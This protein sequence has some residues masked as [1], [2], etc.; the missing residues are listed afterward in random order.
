M[1]S[2]TWPEVSSQ[3]DILDYYYSKIKARENYV[4]SGHMT[5]VLFTRNINH[6]SEA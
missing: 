1:T 4:T 3:D 5:D 6:I 2:V